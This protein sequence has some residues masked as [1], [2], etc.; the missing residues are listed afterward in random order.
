MYACTHKRIDNG[1]GRVVCARVQ[2]IIICSIRPQTKKKKDPRDFVL[3]PRLIELAAPV[4]HR[5]TGS[6]RII[7]Q[8][9]YY[10]VLYVTVCVRVCISAAADANNTTD[11]RP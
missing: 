1:V 6:L 7:L 4:L 10:T 3:F 2:Y 9:T 11:R 5:Q 8:Y